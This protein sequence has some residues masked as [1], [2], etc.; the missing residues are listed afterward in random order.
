MNRKNKKR[1]FVGPAR[2]IIVVLALLLGSAVFAV[3]C[4]GSG[5]SA[6]DYVGHWE[7]TYRVDSGNEYPCHLEISIVGQ[8]LVVKSEDQT[9]KPCENYAQIL[10]LA[11]DGTAKGGPMGMIT[12][13]FDRKANEIIVGGVP[14]SHNL[15][16]DTNYHSL[17]TFFAGA[18]TKVPTNGGQLLSDTLLVEL[19]S[20]GSFKVREKEV[21]DNA[22][23][24][25]VTYEN[26]AIKGTFY[27]AVD[28]EH[29]WPFEIKARGPNIVY[30]DMRGE[31][32]FTKQ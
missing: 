25:N 22:D 7:G 30:S 5:P 27:M 18:W 12:L 31:E 23:F 21:I 4:G 28:A 1:L 17:K 24:Q 2:P 32:S 15:R 26:G 8:S 10:S 20:D 9:F 19:Q 6:Q 29:R 11:G 16:K 13:L 3:A 14:T